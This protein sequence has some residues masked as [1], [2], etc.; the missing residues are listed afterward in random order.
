MSLPFTTAAEAAQFIKNGDAIGFSG[1]T[2]AG[3]PKAVSSELAKLAEAEHAKGNPFRV[4]IYTGASTSDM[5]DGA[6]ARA[7]AVLF[8]TPYQSHK[9]LR[10]AINSGNAPYFDLHLSQLA[11]ELRYGFLKKPDVAIIEA[12]DVS[13]DGAIILTAGVGI[14]PTVARM[15]DRII[16]ELNHH[17]STKQKGMHDI[18]EPQAP[19]HRREIP[20]FTVRDR[21]G[22]PVLKVDP[23]KIVAVVETNLEDGI[24][25][26][27]PP[28]EVTQ[29]IGDNVAL[30]LASELKRGIIPK[31]FLPIQSG[32]GNIAN[33]VL[34][35]LGKNPEIPSF[36]MYTE[37]IQ[38][39]VL[40]LMKEGNINFASGSSLTVTDGVLQDIY[41]NMD[42]FCDKLILRPQE[43]SNNP[44]VV[45]RLGLVTINTALE[46]DI[47][48][49]INSTHVSGTRMMN[50]IGGSGDFTRNAFISIFTAPSVA[51]GG[52][53]SAFVPMVSHH[54]HSEHSVKVLITEHGI[55]DLRGKTPTERA[56][57]IIENCVHPDYKPLLRDFLK[58]SKGG[59]TPQ[60]L[61]ACFAMHQ[62]LQE[63]GNML[64][65]D[66][67]KY[68]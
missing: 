49:N 8:R 14:C 64:D 46:A 2:S 65:T 47:F 21:I 16:I 30:F 26:F 55:A 57:I 37:V 23:K 3:A 31:E 27:T 34:D 24:A 22:V 15:A 13:E 50:G 56:H 33:A 40:G 36:T 12:C 19:P 10:T 60:N 52:K 67:G 53:I 35:S 20:V 43:I 17:H 58:L 66:W 1:F 48:G 25:P 6:L 39:A 59:H 41:N 18:Y 9:D 45:R 68:N 42:F 51:K 11:Q 4:G 7:N 61:Y 38:D 44:E 54:D 32:V 62:Q 29:K 5:L 63:T 28:D